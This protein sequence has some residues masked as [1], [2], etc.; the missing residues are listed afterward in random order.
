ML[1][2][3]TVATEEGYGCKRIERY[4]GQLTRTLFLPDDALS[5]QTSASLKNGV[6]QII[7]PRVTPNSQMQRGEIAIQ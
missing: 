2:S 1:V 6:L 4:S 7:L 5:E 3:V